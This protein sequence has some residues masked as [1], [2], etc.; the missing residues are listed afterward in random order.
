MRRYGLLLIILFAGCAG[1]VEENP[2]PGD[3]L[4]QSTGFL[5][6]F[7]VYPYAYVT[8]N[9]GLSIVDFSDLENPRL[10]GSLPT[11]GQAEGIFVKQNYAFVCDGLGGLKVIDISNP[12]A[13]RL[14]GNFS[15]PGNLKQIRIVGDLAYVANFDD[16]DGL[17]VLNVSDV[18]NITLVGKFDPPGYEHVRDLFVGDELVFLA[19]FTGGMPIVSRETLSL[20]SNYKSRGVAYSVAVE[21]DIALIADSDAGVE[22]V[23]V[24]IPEEPRRITTLHTMGYA[25]KVK[26]REGIAYI[27]TGSAG[28]YVYNLSNP[29]KPERLAH[30]PTQGNAFGF[31]IDGDLLY[32]ADFDNGLVVLNIS[33]PASPRLVSHFA[34]PGAPLK[35]RGGGGN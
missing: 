23:N 35:Y 17:L 10:V 2:S 20:V 32:L 22:V 4:E 18:K 14:V 16:V 27:T 26:L 25:I 13:P 6:V 19:D 7:V 5:D 8:S 34:E 28:L 30:F 24:S 12:H 9:W 3:T 31:F 33:S 11:Q 15:Y 29:A 1:N 21:N